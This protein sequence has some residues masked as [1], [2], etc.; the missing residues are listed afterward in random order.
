[1]QKKPELYFHAVK[2]NKTKN[3]RKEKERLTDIGDK[4]SDIW[5]SRKHLAEIEI[6]ESKEVIKTHKRENTKLVETYQIVEKHQ[7]KNVQKK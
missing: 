5:W 1:M 6:D 3:P 7:M 2:I 4:E